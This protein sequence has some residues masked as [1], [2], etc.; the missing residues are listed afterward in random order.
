MP[1][2]GF[3]ERLLLRLLW[4]GMRAGASPAS[5]RGS[6]HWI[7]FTYWMSLCAWASEQCCGRWGRN[8]PDVPIGEQCGLR[9]TSL[10]AACNVGRLRVRPP[11]AIQ[12]PPLGPAAAPY[13]RCPLSPLLTTHIPCTLPR[14]LPPLSLLLLH[15]S[16][17]R[18]TQRR[19]VCCIPT[20]QHV[21]RSPQ[22]CPKRADPLPP[23]PRVRPQAQGHPQE[24]PAPS[25]DDAVHVRR[26]PVRPFPTP[27]HPTPS[28]LT[29]QREMLT[30]ARAVSSSLSWDEKNIAETDM[31]GEN[32]MKITEP[33]TPYVRYNAELDEVEGYSSMHPF[34]LARLRTRLSEDG[35]A[36]QDIPDFSLT[37][38]SPMSSVPPS[39]HPGPA[40]P[41]P[42]AARTE[43]P[44]RRTSFGYGGSGRPSVSASSGSSRSAS[45]S[46]PGEEGTRV[47]VGEGEW[48]E[49]EEGE[50]LDEE[51][52]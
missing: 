11:E 37:Q 8:V 20:P 33:K 38:R 12:M 30:C 17:T 13:L 21:R 10:S 48:G 2:R 7:Q 22:R 1:G 29:A 43:S 34:P 44:E 4:T 23:A 51:G 50:P 36:D 18:T 27:P 24:R 32:F 9:T 3:D 31:S 52:M 26:S 19:S 28:L 46:L 5:A 40:P 35:T 6:S 39:P 14:A 15:S 49:V 16:H 41:S 47:A 25:A 45:F 42:G